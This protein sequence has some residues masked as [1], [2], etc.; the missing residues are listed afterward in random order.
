MKNRPF[1]LLSILAILGSL[2]AIIAM[3]T[4]TAKAA[5][6]KTKE[7]KS[8]ILALEFAQE[9][10]MVDVVFEKAKTDPETL[11][12]KAAHIG[13][14]TALDLGFI[15]AYA[16][17]MLFFALICRQ[18]GIKTAWLPA[19]AIALTAAFADVREN[20]LLQQ[21]FVKVCQ[22]TP[23]YSGIFGPLRSWTLL[24][25]GSIAAFFLLMGPFFWK[26]NWIGKL[27]VTAAGLSFFCL[28]MILL[29]S[30]AYWADRLFLMI[31]LAFS[32][33]MVFGIRYQ[34][35]SPSI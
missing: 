28:G 15:L 1:L 14:A 19:M 24:K 11:R 4:A 12:Q 7:Y 6:L 30:P 25:F 20:A 16:G 10:A 2:S 27:V 34:A 8:S 35:N 32:G 13:F 23:D 21:I 26:S 3:N 9:P 5:L 31:F 17:F 18:K 33:A 22:D 29:D